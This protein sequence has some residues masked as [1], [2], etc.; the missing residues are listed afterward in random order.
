[1]TRKISPS[2]VTVSL[3][4]ICQ[5]EKTTLLDANGKQIA[6]IDTLLAQQVSLEM[7]L[8]IERDVP[9][10]WHDKHHGWRAAYA[11]MKS[12]YFNWRTRL[13]LIGWEKKAHTWG[14]SIRR[15]RNKNRT[16]PPRKTQFLRG[17]RPRN[18]EDWEAACVSFRLR[19]AGMIIKKKKRNEDPWLLWAETVYSNH[20]KKRDINEDRRQRISITGRVSKNP[21]TPGIQMCFEWS[22]DRSKA[23]FA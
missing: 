1:M 12:Q 4:A 19:Y 7:R 16:R 5:G 10:E 15:R 2:V 8:S 17:G 18:T 20:R 11:R 14:T 13:H 9:I 23:V 22:A 6:V 3:T 21:R